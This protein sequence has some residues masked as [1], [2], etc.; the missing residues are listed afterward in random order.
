MRVE[1]HGELQWVIGIWL[2]TG[3]DVHSEPCGV[4]PFVGL[5]SFWKAMEIPA[6]LE[7]TPEELS[8]QGETMIAASAFPV[9]SELVQMH[10]DIAD[11]AASN[12]PNLILELEAGRARCSDFW[13]LTV[14]D[15]M[16]KCAMLAFSRSDGIFLSPSW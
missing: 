15:E 11:V 5:A 3:R 13:G 8:M 10:I 7:G 9:L 4:I 1:L 2:M 16:K 12:I 6:F 14:F